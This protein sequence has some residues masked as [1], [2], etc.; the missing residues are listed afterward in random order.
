[1][2]H[3]SR[4]FCCCTF[5]IAGY[6]NVFTW[7]LKVTRVRPYFKQWENSESIAQ[8]QAGLT[9]TCATVWKC[10]TLWKR[11]YPVTTGF[12]LLQLQRT[13]KKCGVEVIAMPNGSG[14]EWET[15]PIIVFLLLAK[16]WSPDCILSLPMGTGQK[17]VYVVQRCDLFVLLIW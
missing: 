14:K 17:F 13:R 2:H 10:A 8:R 12:E 15:L 5:G 16:A 6:M 11:F 7:S 1:M 9:G 4:G 3:F